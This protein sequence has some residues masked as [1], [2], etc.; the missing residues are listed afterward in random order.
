[1]V[2]MVIIMDIKLNIIC[3]ATIKFK[4]DIKNVNQTDN[5][6]GGQF[7]NIIILNIFDLVPYQINI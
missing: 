7:S 6:N 1:M 2:I 3:A 5:I 4:W